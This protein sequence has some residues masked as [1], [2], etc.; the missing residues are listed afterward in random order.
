MGYD[1]G[2]MCR[3]LA[4]YGA[5]VPLE[6]L[7]FDPDSSLVAQSYAPQMLE[8]LNLAGFGMVA[9]DDASRAPAEPFVYKTTELPFFDRNLRAL[10]AKVH[11]RCLVAHVRGVPHTHRAVVNTQN[12]HPFQLAGTRLSLAHNGDLADFAA[13]KY[14]LLEHVK[15]EIARAVGGTTDSEWIFALVVSQLADPGRIDG[16]EELVRAIDRALGVLRRVRERHG[17]RRASSVNLFMSDGRH[18]VA[19]RFVF[20]FGRYDGAPHPASLD[21][22]SLWYT[23]GRTYGLH[24]REWKMIGGPARAD[25]LI[26]ASEPLTRDASTWLAVPEYSAIYATGETGHGVARV[27]ERAA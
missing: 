25:S 9:W 22:L 2:R 12:V 7:L 23:T 11:A 10:A 21:F 19:T 20:D 4:Y 3:V 1:R 18:L 16:A 17:I 15:P 13:M 27:V 6:Q 8:M 24:D 14:D 26:L 5:P